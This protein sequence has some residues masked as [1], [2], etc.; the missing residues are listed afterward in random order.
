MRLTGAGGATGFPLGSSTFLSGSIGPNGGGPD[1]G[2]GATLTTQLIIL[3]QRNNKTY[4]SFR[5]N[6]TEMMRGAGITCATYWL[7]VCWWSVCSNGGKTN[8]RQKLI[9]LLKHRLTFSCFT[10]SS[11]Y[12][13]TSLTG[14]MVILMPLY[15]AAPKWGQ[16]VSNNQRTTEAENLA[17][18]NR[19]TK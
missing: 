8:I 9:A 2:W 3:K 1:S 5:L 16:P 12:S 17:K 19:E 18:R 14:Q 6:F 11:F 15:S 4:S 7:A 10:P 13:L